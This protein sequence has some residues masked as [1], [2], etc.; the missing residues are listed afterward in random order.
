MTHR[1]TLVIALV[2]VAVLGAMSIA[3]GAVNP[4]AGAVST[5]RRDGKLQFDTVNWW[6]P[7][8]VTVHGVQDDDADDETVSVSLAVFGVLR[9]DYD[10]VATPGVSISVDDDD[11]SVLTG[12][13]SGRWIWRQGCSPARDTSE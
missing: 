3:F 10:G 8:S 12:P 9:G 6:K 1:Q 2:L 5:S 11:E 4:G 7:Q 13:W